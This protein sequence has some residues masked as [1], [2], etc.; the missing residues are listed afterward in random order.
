MD[1]MVMDEDV[2]KHTQTTLKDALI[3]AFAM[4]AALFA[5]EGR[6]PDFTRVAK[7]IA[8]YVALVSF[9]KINHSEVAKQVA[10]AAAIGCGSKLMDVLVK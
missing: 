1:A 2:V 7:F 6:M 8:V 9:L 10:S 4:I 3:L 5:A